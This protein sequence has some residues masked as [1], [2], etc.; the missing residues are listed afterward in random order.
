MRNVRLTIFLLFILFSTG[1]K[2]EG[3]K[4]YNGFVNTIERKCMADI[5]KA[6]LNGRKNEMKKRQIIAA[7]GIEG[8]GLLDKGYTMWDD[9]SERLIIWDSQIWRDVNGNSVVF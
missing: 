8:R 5:R 6:V 2:L 7:N 3:K 4:Y 9:K 1:N